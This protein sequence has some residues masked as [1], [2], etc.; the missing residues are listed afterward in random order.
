VLLSVLRADESRVLT[1]TVPL[2]V[3]D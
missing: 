1:F 3:L 2:I